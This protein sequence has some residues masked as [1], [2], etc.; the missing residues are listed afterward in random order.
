L[1]TRLALLLSFIL[2]CACQ[3]VKRDKKETLVILDWLPNPNHI[4]LYAGMDQGIFQKHG[5]HLRILKVIDPS[6][7]IPY[8]TSQQVDLALSYMPHS[9]HAIDHGAEIVPIG[10]LI[11]EPL[12]GLIYRAN[13]GIDQPEDLNHAT[14][15]YSVDGYQAKFLETMF[16]KK[17]ITPKKMYSVSFDLTMPLASRQV[18]CLYGAYW[19]IECENLRALGIETNFFPLSDFEVPHYYE[20][21][22]LA[23]KHS[24]QASEEFISRFK[25]ALQESIDF[26]VTQ[27]DDAFKSYLKYNPDKSARTIA[28]ERAAWNKTIPTLATT[29][30]IDEGLWNHFVDWLRANQMLNH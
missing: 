23:R 17:K 1:N 3:Q 27:S 24:L 9:I 25:K 13:D 18:D 16:S 14:I 6:D 20:L 7:S 21:I 5:I 22:F 11:R 4:A 28:W 30:T 19:N 29:Q 8:L 10:I 15:G 12:N 2:L 26:S